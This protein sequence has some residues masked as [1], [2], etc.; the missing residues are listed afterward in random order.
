MIVDEYEKAMLELLD[1]GK[2]TRGDRV[3]FAFELDACEVKEGHD[4]RW[5]REM[6][7]VAK[8]GDRFFK[9]NWMAGLTE[10]QDNDFDED[11]VEVEKVITEKIVK[12][13]TWNTIDN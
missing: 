10:S 1:A 3:N 5:Q 7:T 11:P 4:H 13:I 9:M 2:F 8:L 12:V 6:T